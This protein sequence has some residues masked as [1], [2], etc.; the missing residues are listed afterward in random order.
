M[1]IYIKDKKRY[2]TETAKTVASWHNGHYA[3]D[4]KSC[5]ETLYKTPKGAY[6]IVGEGGPMSKYGKQIGNS[7]HWGTGMRVITEAEAVDWLEET[8]NIDALQNLFSDH[9]KDA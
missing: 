3:N 6:F 8:D 1:T 9:I 7:R 4:F 2:N 5:E